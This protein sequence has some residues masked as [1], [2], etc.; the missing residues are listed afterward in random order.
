MMKRLRQ[1]AVLPTILNIAAFAA[2]A[3]AAEAAKMQPFSLSQNCDEW[4]SGVPSFCTVTESNVPAL[5]KGTRVLYY[6]PVNNKIEFSSNNVV[7]DDGAGNTALGNCI[8]DYDA[9]K[10]MCAFYAGNGSLLSFTAIAEVSVDDNQVWHWNGSYRIS[11][12][13]EPSK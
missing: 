3:V 1:L 8:V 7:L 4:T 13:A 11:P 12:S 9:S 5:K 2:P 10:G 6:V